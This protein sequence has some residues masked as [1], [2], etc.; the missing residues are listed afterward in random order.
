M[1]C[2]LFPRGNSESLTVLAGNQSQTQSQTMPEDLWRFFELLSSLV[3]RFSKSLFELRGSDKKKRGDFDALRSMTSF[4]PVI[5]D[6]LGT[7]LQLLLADLF[8]LFARACRKVERFLRS[9]KKRKSSRILVLI[10]DLNQS[11]VENL[12]RWPKV[13][14]LDDHSED[15]TRGSSDV[16]T[17]T[18]PMKA[19]PDQRGSPMTS[20]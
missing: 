16:S 3:W 14:P 1:K 6:S 2:S 17:T 18:R 12:L 13:S 8:T 5:E 19:R 11:K 7:F 9:S 20:V 10:S 15:S 4:C